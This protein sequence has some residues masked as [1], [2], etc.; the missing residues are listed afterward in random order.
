[1]SEYWY[2]SHRLRLWCMVFYSCWV[3]CWCFWRFL[4]RNRRGWISGWGLIFCC[5]DIVGQSMLAVCILP[6][7]ETEV[8]SVFP[9]L[10]G[11]TFAFWAG[12]VAANRPPAAA[13]AAVGLVAWSRPGL[14][15]MTFL[16]VAVDE[17][18]LVACSSAVDENWR[19][20]GLKRFL[21]T[22]DVLTGPG[23]LLGCFFLTPLPK[24]KYS[25]FVVT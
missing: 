2:F 25:S 20:A 23:G 18:A 17:W 7:M 22:V 1:M 6:G 14:W 8:V 19:V 3:C 10:D 4:R 5:V 11:F 13:A 15:L 24:R 16:L 9:W 21:D 12:R